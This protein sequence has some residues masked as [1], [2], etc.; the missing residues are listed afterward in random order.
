LYA[1]EKTG[2]FKGLYH[3]LGGA[4]SPLDGIGPEKLRIHELIERLKSSEIRKLSLQLVQRSGDA[5][6]LYLNKILKPLGVS[7]S[8]IAFGLPFGTELQ[9]ADENTLIRALEEGGSWIRK[10][11]KRGK[12]THVYGHRFTGPAQVLSRS[13]LPSLSSRQA[14]AQRRK[15]SSMNAFERSF[16]AVNPIVI[17]TNDDIFTMP[18]N[19]NRRD[20]L[21]FPSRLLQ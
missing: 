20:R 14:P 5:T 16:P 13:Y 15:S 10:R 9:S 21:S 4:I 19:R 6:C 17:E 7:L 1:M 2:Q 18:S 11:R 3:I 8:R 12:M